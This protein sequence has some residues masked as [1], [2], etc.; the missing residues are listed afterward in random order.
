MPIFNLYG[1]VV[2]MKDGK[3]IIELLIEMIKELKGLRRDI[4]ALSRLK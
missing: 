3:V 2:K 1:Y 4:K